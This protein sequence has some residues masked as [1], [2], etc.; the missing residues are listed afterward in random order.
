M[1]AYEV[2]GDEEK[3]RKYDQF[4]RYEISRTEWT[5]IRSQF[6]NFEFRKSNNGFSDFF[7]MFL[8]TAA[9]IWMIYSERAEGFK[10]FNKGFSGTRAIRG[11]YRGGAGHYSEEGLEG[12]KRLLRSEPVK[13]K[14]PLGKNTQGYSRRR[15]DQTGRTGE[16]PV[17]GNR[18][19]DLYIN[20]RF[21]EGKY[22]LGR[23]Q[24]D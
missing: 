3:R 1:E 22:K 14:N 16:N 9:S 18:S 12:L 11:E 8:V 23:Q 17:S 19:G 24:P 10:G 20:I 7:N 6:G 13:E 21:K 5:L 15:K 4:G 2:L